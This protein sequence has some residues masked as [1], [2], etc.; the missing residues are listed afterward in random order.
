MINEVLKNNATFLSVRGEKINEPTKT[1]TS[2]DKENEEKDESKDAD[3]VEKKEDEEKGEAEGES[4][5]KEETPAI[6][7]KPTDSKNKTAN[8][9]SLVDEP[10]QQNATELARESEKNK[11]HESSDE[12]TG[13]KAESET[14]KSIEKEKPK[15]KTKNDTKPIDKEVTKEEK[16]PEKSKPIEEK[17]FSE[18]DKHFKSEKTNKT[19]LE[20]EQSLEKEKPEGKKKEV[21][22]TEK[23]LGNNQT[24]EGKFEEEEK[25][26]DEI[27]QQVD[28]STEP[29]PKLSEESETKTT[30][31][32]TNK[33]T[34]LLDDTTGVTEID[35]TKPTEKENINS[36]I[37]STERISDTNIVKDQDGLVDEN[38]NDD[39]NVYSTV[40]EDI[41]SFSN[42]TV[43]EI[44]STPTTSQIHSTKD[45]EVSDD[46]A[47]SS[48]NYDS[49]TYSE[50]S[51][52]TNVEIVPLESSTES[53]NNKS[54]LTEKS[55]EESVQTEVAMETSENGTDLLKHKTTL[56]TTISPETPKDNH[57]DSYQE[58]QLI[59]NETTTISSLSTTKKL[60]VENE[61]IHQDI[62]TNT[63]KFVEPDNETVVAYTKDS[64][65]T[66]PT[67]TKSHPTDSA[68]PDMFLTVDPD[69]NKV[70][71]EKSP[72]P[73]ST[74]LSS[75][76]LVPGETSVSLDTKNAS[77]NNFSIAVPVTTV[78]D[79]VLGS[80]TNTKD[81]T[82]N[83]T[84][85]DKISDTSIETTLQSGKNNT[86][87]PI[88]NEI[89][90]P[91][92]E[93]DIRDTIKH[94]TLNEHVSSTTSTPLSPPSL[95]T[96]PPPASIEASSSTTAADIT[97]PSTI[98]SAPTI[99]S[100]PKTSDV[101]SQK[102]TKSIKIEELQPKKTQTY[103]GKEISTVTGGPIHIVTEPIV[104]S[105]EPQISSS[106][107]Q[108]IQ[109]STLVAQVATQNP[110][111]NSQIDLEVIS[112][113]SHDLSSPNV[114]K[115]PSVDASE[116]SLPGESVN[117][118]DKSTVSST[119]P[120][121]STS[122]STTTTIPPCSSGKM[123]NCS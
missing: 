104:T 80:S 93:T 50:D 48:I 63:S 26:Q 11:T 84:N 60:I 89:A 81:L 114:D 98:T 78:T 39:K 41:S 76:S 62:L 79:Y 97:S 29:K 72:E 74:S 28:E 30:E 73:T 14:D 90:G 4:K 52:E 36:K 65:T 23:P 10:K 103:P 1:K 15:E 32:I 31:T 8:E 109:G 16:T 123:G 75:E 46:K 47:I 3:E 96:P 54:K 17:T 38:G 92:N 6:A 7:E 66:Q 64:N 105:S 37:E 53:T 24:V 113:V 119:S 106:A 9:T 101:H 121:S 83:D 69:L 57:T 120:T 100:S 19:E 67:N 34:T 40:G 99:S 85:A 118:T 58:N 107:T 122:T 88:V 77:Y 45:S 59:T 91:Q 22:T 2:E 20:K 55:E 13:T 27:P 70:S 110:Q 5:P 95:P 33:Q 71:D 86:L 102:T 116:S 12:R 18:E 82:E 94:T 49:R 44:V 87:T 56:L 51:T 43:V 68:V 112:D 21:A 111:V 117:V 61:T 25:K 115:I 42:G 108:P 35:E